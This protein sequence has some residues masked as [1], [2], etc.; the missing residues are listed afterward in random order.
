M[1]KNMPK[2]DSAGKVM[3]KIK[4]FS[5]SDLVDKLMVGSSMSELRKSLT[6]LSLLM[7]T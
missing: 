6:C 4:E 5:Q 2:T 1:V 3:E 7:I